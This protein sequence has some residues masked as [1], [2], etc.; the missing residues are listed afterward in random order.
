MML[1]TSYSCCH[2]VE[3]MLKC[4]SAISKIC[5]VYCEKLLETYKTQFLLLQPASYRGQCVFKK[6]FLITDLALMIATSRHSGGQCMAFN[7]FH[8]F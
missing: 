4:S 6:Y 7:C 3:S 1:I 8:C 5:N 2:L